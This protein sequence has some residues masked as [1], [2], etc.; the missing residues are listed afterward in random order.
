MGLEFLRGEMILCDGNNRGEMETMDGCDSSKRIR[1]FSTVHRVT[2]RKSE[3]DGCH[4]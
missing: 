3:Y 1:A 2:R 4:E